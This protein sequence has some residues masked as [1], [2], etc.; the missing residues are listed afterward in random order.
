MLDALTLRGGFEIP[1]AGA[2]AD[3]SSWRATP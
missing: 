2:E 3:S 1:G